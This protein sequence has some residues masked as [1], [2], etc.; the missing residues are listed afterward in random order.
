MDA[1][2]ESDNCGSRR[3]HVGE[4]GFTYCTEGH[5]QSQMTVRDLWALRLSTLQMRLASAE[6]D[7]ELTTQLFSS[8]GETSDSEGASRR[9]R[10]HRNEDALPRAVDGIC[11]VFAGLVLLRLPVTVADVLRRIHNGQLIY[12]RASQHLDPAMK[13]VLAGTYHQLLDPREKISLSR[14]Q[15]EVSDSLASLSDGFGISFPPLN[16][17]LCLWRWTRMLCLP[18]EVYPCTLRLASLLSISFDYYDPTKHWPTRALRLPEQRLAALLIMATKLLFPPD[19][20]ERTPRKPTEPAALA[21][22]WPAWSKVMREQSSLKR[23]PAF[24]TA[25]DT[26]EQDVSSMSA[27][28]MDAYMAWYGDMYTAPEPSG[29]KRRIRAS[30][31]P[32]MHALRHLFPIESAEVSHPPAPQSQDREVAIREAQASL[33]PVRVLATHADEAV[34]RPGTG[35]ARFLTSRELT[36]HA[37]ELYVHVADC[38]GTELDMLVRDVFALERGLERL[39]TADDTEVG[40][41]TEG[42]IVE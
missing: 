1:E 21:M 3:F 2:C 9:S 7:D 38:V 11:L 32:L 37:R 4:D 8:Q 10:S 33:R 16:H 20:R 25:L 12:Y 5:R 36:G 6:R 13:A 42:L 14:L 31:Q 39:A 30:T 23:K 28:D 26:T 29:P 19:A 17:H 18:L 40:D 22:D 41:E 27:E 24:G 34:E 15:R 35:Y